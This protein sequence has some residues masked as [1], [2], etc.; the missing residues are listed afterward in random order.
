MSRPAVLALPLILALAP[1]S[2]AAQERECARTIA[3]RVVEARTGAPVPGALV[4]VRT[5][6][7]NEVTTDEQGRFA[8]EAMPCAPLDLQVAMLGYALLERRVDGGAD[9]STDVRLSLTEAPPPYAEQVTVAGDPFADGTGGGPAA[10]RIG[11]SDLA[12]L[13]GV[14]ADDPFRAVQAMPGVAS[15]D[16]FTAEFAIRG[17]GPAHV[18][19]LIDGV[20]APVVL[21]TIQ[22]RSDTGSVS[23]INSDLLD[24]VSVTGGSYAARTGNRTGGQVS[25]ATRDGSRESTQVRTLLSAAV[26]SLAAEGPLGAARQASWLVAA[27]GSYAGW[28]ARRVDPSMDT[29]FL[30][31]DANAKL[32]WDVSP[33]H[34]LSLLAIVGRMDV[35]ERQVDEG[36]NTLDEGLNESAFLV[37]SWRWQPTPT[38]SVAQH[39]SAIY[40]RFRNLNAF[41]HE[42]GR[43]RVSGGSHR[44]DVSW[45]GGPS[46]VLEAGG[47]VDTRAEDI[48]LRRRTSRPPNS[49]VLEAVDASRRLWGAY[50]SV[51]S[52]PV[53]SL[54]WTAGA[55][56]DVSSD[57]SWGALTPWGH[58]AWTVAD[59]WSLRG[60]AGQYVQYPSLLQ[61]SGTRGNLW[62]KPMQ[63]LHLDLALE[64]R[65]S[66]S[67]RWHVGV[68]HR[69]E[70]DKWRM[71]LAEPRLLD[72]RVFGG[73]IASTWSNRLDG[74]ARGVEALVERRV[75]T[76]LSG[77]I[78]YSHGRTRDR[79][80][81]SGERFA[82]DYDQR[83]TF[84]AFLSWRLSHRAGASARVSYGSGFPVVGYYT[85]A[86]FADD[87]EPAYGLSASRNGARYPA[88]ARVDLRAQRAFLRGDRRVTLFA[89]VVNALNRANYGP[90][91]PGGAEKLFPV[92]PSAG[93]LVEW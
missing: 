45:V 56:G 68:Y 5:G 28:I 31:V 47:S 91:S 69:G 23:M 72:D 79:D 54:T 93:I 74:R 60:G 57:S 67:V 77:W 86:G 78:A 1:W 35:E 29:A 85:P 82:A 62:L 88:Y 20:P 30:F 59:G 26:A 22:G 32:A 13:R 44:V 40:N 11:T 80:V 43:G 21:H 66:A 37:G 70:H 34:R 19:I 3:G 71:P 81:V 24:E 87:G 83:H 42:L 49:L 92:L 73:S 64:R 46:W 18:G 10:M 58:A 14:L 50:A 36:L 75:P 38:L 61:S 15:G 2:V 41:G 7:A 16:D 55:R 17:A 12:L 53:A 48:V 90:G 52:T 65:V 33:S 27:R 51:T 9:G 39:A 6:V 89:E 25:F 4:R 8:L 76:G 63:A 84:N